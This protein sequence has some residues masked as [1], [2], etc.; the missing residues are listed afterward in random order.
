MC[1]TQNGPEE[2]ALDVC[3]DVIASTALAHRVDV[4]CWPGPRGCVGATWVAVMGRAVV[5]RRRARRRAQYTQSA[6][7]ASRL[8]PPAEEMMHGEGLGPPPRTSRA[9]ALMH[10]IFQG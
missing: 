6:I 10:V 8:T 2:Q 3:N 9:A 1:Q 7:C 4:A 5:N